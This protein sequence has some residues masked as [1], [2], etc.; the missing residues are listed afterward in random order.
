MIIIL[1]IGDGVVITI[2]MH[3]FLFGFLQPIM[4]ISPYE[5]DP[6]KPVLI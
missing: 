3:F 6:L 4:E 5:N 2:I 1:F